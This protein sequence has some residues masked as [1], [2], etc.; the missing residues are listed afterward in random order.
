MTE[1]LSWRTEAHKILDDYERGVTKGRITQTQLSSAIGVCRQ[2]LW[3]DKSIISRIAQIQGINSAPGKITKSRSNSEMRIRALEV[4]V[5]QLKKENGAL[6]QNI[7][8]ACK[9]LREKGLDPREFV[10]ETEVYV[11]QASSKPSE[12]SFSCS[13]R[14]KLLTDSPEG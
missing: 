11:Q 6:I 13:T 8:L 9:K 3:R 7:V 10:S 12:E 2:T 5:T 1:K 4:L 14:N